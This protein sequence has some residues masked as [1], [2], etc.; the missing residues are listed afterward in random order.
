MGN[1]DTAFTMMV[2]GVSWIFIVLLEN[3]NLLD[4]FL[5]WYLGPIAIAFGVYEFF[6]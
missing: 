3:L 5:L 4:V 6:R 2:M 1:K